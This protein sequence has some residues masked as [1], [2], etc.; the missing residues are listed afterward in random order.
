AG[1]AN[2]AQTDSAKFARPDRQVTLIRADGSPLLKLAFD[3]TA[4]G[5]WVRGGE[6]STVYRMDTWSADRLTPSDST[7][8][9]KPAKS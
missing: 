5:F 2:P 7:L 3:S 8:K 4:T 1:F 9:P 6:D